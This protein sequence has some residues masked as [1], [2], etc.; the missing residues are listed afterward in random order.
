MQIIDAT[1]TEKLAQIVDALCDS[2]ILSIPEFVKAP[3]P[4]L[5]FLRQMEMT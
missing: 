4:C 3:Q 2:R 1:V 5:S